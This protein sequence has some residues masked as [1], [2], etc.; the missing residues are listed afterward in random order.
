MKVPPGE[1]AAS[2][3]MLPDGRSLLFVLAPV[4]GGD[5]WEAAEVVVQRLDSGE[6]KSVVKGGS[7]ARYV[8]TGH[9]VYAR[10]GVLFAAPFDVRRLELTG[11]PVPIVEGV[12][13][14][15]NSGEAHVAFS[16]T[17]SMM[18]VPGPPVASSGQ[19]HLVLFDRSGTVERLTLPRGAYQRPRVSPDGRASA[20]CRH[21]RWHGSQYLGLRHVGR[22][23][24]SAS[25]VRRQ[26]QG[27]GMDGQQRADRVPVGS[28]RRPGGFLAA[29]GRQR[30]A[31]APDPAGAGTVAPSQRLVADRR[32]VVVQQQHRRQHLALD[33]VAPRPQGCAVWWRA[34]VESAE[35][36]VLARRP[37]GWRTTRTTPKRA[38]TTSSCSAFRALVPSTRFQVHQ[39][40]STRSGPLV[41]TSSITRL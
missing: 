36:V 10:S 30:H 38:R 41:E 18:Y 8:P 26:E 2:P 22:E 40:R 3:Q 4:V 5:R 33:V 17:G 7:D 27:S 25:D 31:R 6:R 12:A 39:T 37:G 9:L 16:Q 28:R 11:V 19:R 23:P 1:L 34:V 14:A 29:R 20:C 21:R 13:R 24:P 35:R 15:V 32:Y